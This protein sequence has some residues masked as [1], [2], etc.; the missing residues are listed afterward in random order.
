MG[1]PLTF[2]LDLDLDLNQ[3][4]QADLRVQWVCLCLFNLDL[5]LILDLDL[6]Q[7]RQA[8]LRELHSDRLRQLVHG[9]LLGGEA[10][11][12]LIEHLQRERGEDSFRTYGIPYSCGNNATDLQPPGKSRAGVP[13]LHDLRRFTPPNPAD[14]PPL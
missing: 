6:N 11:K 2:S 13:G 8:D 4:L 7:D 3:V 9:S 12:H 10:A 5:D 1:L 14:C